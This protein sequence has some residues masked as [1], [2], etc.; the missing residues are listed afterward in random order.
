ME[1]ETEKAGVQNWLKRAKPAQPQ[2]KAL[3]SPS[4]LAPAARSPN[5]GTSAPKTRSCD[6]GLVTLGLFFRTVSRPELA[7]KAGAPIGHA[8]WG[9]R[10]LA[11]RETGGGEKG[12]RPFPCP[13]LVPSAGCRQ[14]LVRGYYANCS[15]C[16]NKQG[17]RE[18]REGVRIDCNFFK[19]SYNPKHTRQNQKRIWEPASP[20]WTAFKRG[21]RD[22]ERQRARIAIAKAFWFGVKKKNSPRSLQ[23]ANSF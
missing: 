14:R 7:L 17:D 6:P 4:S 18:R 5:R 8:P 11:G 9:R 2:A 22:S 23:L 10:R 13:L 1:K 21:E 3:Y 20:G 12:A 16:G 19:V 15:D